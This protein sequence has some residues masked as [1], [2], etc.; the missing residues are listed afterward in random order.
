[1][2]STTLNTH[3]STTKPPR[4]KKSMASKK[5]PKKEITVVNQD[6]KC[7][8]DTADCT[9]HSYPDDVYNDSISILRQWFD[10]ATCKSIIESLWNYSCHYVGN[11]NLDGSFVMEKY[12]RCIYEDKLNNIISSIEQYDANDTQGLLYKIKNGEI[13]AFTIPILK[14]YELVPSKFNELLSRNKLIEEKKNNIATT[15]AYKCYKCGNN[16]C[17][18][19]QVQTR[20]ADEPM[21]IFVTCQ[22]CGF[23]FRQ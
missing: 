4:K 7:C 5:I 16:K 8:T 18:V 20:S 12:K 15:T 9:I 14:P 13:D 23:V 2:S 6:K 17:T 11:K 19:A 22:V 21:T 3:K 10:E 1:M